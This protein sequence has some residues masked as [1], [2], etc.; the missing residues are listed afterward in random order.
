MYRMMMSEL[1]DD[2]VHVYFNR[3]H[4]DHCRCIC[5][6]V[7]HSLCSG[8]PRGATDSKG[9]VGTTRFFCGIEQA[10][11]PSKIHP[12]TITFQ[13]RKKCFQGSLRHTHAYCMC[14][15]FDFSPSVCSLRIYRNKRHAAQWHMMEARVRTRAFF[16]FQKKT[17]TTSG[18]SF[19]FST[20]KRPICFAVIF[21]FFAVD[22]QVV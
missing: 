14:R 2:V 9:W 4:V 3:R 12:P 15:R 5:A 10:V 7:A 8:R 21:A 18:D 13:V 22:L 11:C 17:T 1:T 19:H 16:S 6:Y 20:E